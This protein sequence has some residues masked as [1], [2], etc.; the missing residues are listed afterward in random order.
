MT[1]INKK[2]CSFI[3]KQWLLPWLKENKSQNSFAKAHDIEES[4]IRKIKSENNY[5]VPVETLYKMCK[6]RN[7][8]LED[9]FKLINE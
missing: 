4:T 2:I 3:T 1:D 6:A 7:I 8:T 9:F 5:R